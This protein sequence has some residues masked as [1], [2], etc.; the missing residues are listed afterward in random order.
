MTLLL[1]MMLPNINDPNTRPKAVQT[2]VIATLRRNASTISNIEIFSSPL[3]AANIAENAGA[4]VR[5]NEKASI[6]EIAFIHKSE[7]L[8]CV[9][10]YR[11]KAKPTKMHIIENLSKTV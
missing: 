2:P 1:G 10:R 11:P 7:S 5:T 8:L 9:A 6:N 4:T 3:M